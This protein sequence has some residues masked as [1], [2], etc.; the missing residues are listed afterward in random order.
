MET[1][2]RGKEFA[3]SAEE[4]ERIASEL[5]PEPARKHAIIVGGRRFPPKQ[6]L[7]AVLEAKG[8]NM[9]RLAYTSK[10]AYY[11]F[12]RLGFDHVRV[13]EKDK[14]EGLRALKMLKGIVALG[15]D[16]L[17]DSERYYD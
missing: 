16:A 6:L 15:G 4:V 14:R 11:L 10:D 17:E 8:K 9:D 3:V 1:V 7:E 2:L 12:T 13:D 5:S